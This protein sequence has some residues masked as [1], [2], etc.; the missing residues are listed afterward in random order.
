M[1]SLAPLGLVCFLQFSVTAAP[2][3]TFTVTNT[4]DSGPGSFRQ[5]ILDANATPGA[6]TIAFNIPGTGVHTISPLSPLPA[7]VGDAGTK[8]DGYTQPG[9]S[10]NTLAVGDNAVLLIELNGTALGAGQFGLMLRSSSNLARGLV[11]DG[12]GALGSGGGGIL[13]E[14]GSDNMVSGCFLGTDA[15]GLI[16]KPNEFGVEI[17][18]SEV[19]PFPLPSRTTIG[20]T[21][22]SQRNLISGN[23][24]T[25]ILIGVGASDTVVAGN[26]IGTDVTGNASLANPT[27][28][29]LTISFGNTIGGSTA[30]SGN[31]ISGNSGSGILIFSTQA[32]IQGNRIGTNSTGSSPVP[33]GTGVQIQVGIP[34]ILVGGDV[35]G[36]GNLISGNSFYGVRMFRPSGAR[37]VGNRI[38]TDASG[39]NALG[40]ARDGVLIVSGSSAAGGSG[41]VSGNVIA[42][43]AGAGVAVGSNASEGSSG[44]R[45]SGNSI[46]E[47][48]GLGIDLGSDG[49]T[50]NDPGDGDTGPN[51]LQNY[52][53]LSA[54]LSDGISTLIQGTLDSLPATTFTIEFF[55]SPSCDS[56]GNGEGQT[57]LGETS[58]TTDAFGKA[59]FQVS[60]PSGSGNQVVTA[61]AT[62][63]TGNTSEF[64]ACVGVTF[65]TLPSSVPT[66]DVSICCGW[67]CSS[68][69]RECLS[70]QEPGDRSSLLGC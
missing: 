43:N 39:A 55:A 33:N 30:G 40:N 7:L 16:A 9:S 42:F 4:S 69:P 38:G 62:D 48:G 61:T 29:G 15:A 57:F 12:F 20:G 6:D 14:S 32:V 22:P 60:V 11:I 64:S 25:G 53:V 37:V 56:S 58:V 46:H 10:A 50:V 68:P 51:S 44:N 67:R 2:A 59:S 63:P 65:A 8:L 24:S 19:L 18:Q 41:S 35:P 28:I 23:A 49:V 66:L 52:P 36:A 70:S 31:L 26:Y 17:A 45:I 1:R 54:A 34:D 13:I 5:A 21:S 27:G 47:N 3:A